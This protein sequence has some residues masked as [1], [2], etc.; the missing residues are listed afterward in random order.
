[1]HLRI[2]AK[3]SGNGGAGRSNIDG[4]VRGHVGDSRNLSQAL[5]GSWIG[6]TGDA[7]YSVKDLLHVEACPLEISSHLM[8]R[9]IAGNRD[10]QWLFLFL[11]S[12]GDSLELNSAIGLLQLLH[13]VCTIIPRRKQC[14][15]AA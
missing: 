13:H 12:H 8:N 4:I 15:G 7:A 14:S 2:S 3:R 10:Y 6:G 11:A 5:D 1:M 9:T